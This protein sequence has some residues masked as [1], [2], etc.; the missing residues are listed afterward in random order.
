MR[1]VSQDLKDY[2]DLQLCQIYKIYIELEK[3]IFLQI[4]IFFLHLYTKI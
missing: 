4:T 2:A 1:I 3:L